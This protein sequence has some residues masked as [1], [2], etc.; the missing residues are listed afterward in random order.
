VP[1]GEGTPPDLVVSF[2]GIQCAGVD[3]AP[4]KQGGFCGLTRDGMKCHVEVYGYKDGE[5]TE[6]RSYLE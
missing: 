6:T 3:N 5:Y 1:N 2:R 4:L